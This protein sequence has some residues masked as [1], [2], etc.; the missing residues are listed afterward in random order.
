MSG[1]PLALMAGLVLLAPCARAD[2]PTAG[3]TAFSF[4]STDVVEHLDDVTGAVRVHYSVDGPSVTVLDDAD[5]DG[6]PDFPQ[7]VAS[8]GA[9][10]LDHYSLDMGLRPPVS[11]AELGFGRLGGSDAFDFYL[12]DFGGSSDGQFGVDGCTEVPQRCSGFMVMENDFAGYGYANLEQA[13][14]VLTSHELF[15]AV[16]AAYDGELPVWVSEGTAAW[17]ERTYDPGSRDFF[18]FVDAYFDDTGRSIDRPPTGPVPA[19][20]YATA[21]WWDFLT[22]RHDDDLIGEYLTAMERTTPAPQDALLTLSAVLEARGDALEEAWST[23]ARWNLATGR[24]AGLAESY[25]YAGDVGV[26]RATAQG[27]FIDEEHRFYPLAASYFHVDHTGGPLWFGLDEGAPHLWFAVFRVADGAVD[28]PV[29][30]PVAVWEGTDA[31]AFALA[32]GADLPAGG[33]WMVGSYSAIADSSVR[34]RVCLGDE[35]AASAC[36]PPPDTGEDTGTD[37]PGCGCASGGT[38][39][40]SALLG[41]IA[42]LGLRR[43]R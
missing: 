18:Q 42:L 39:S 4:E 10:V 11:E 38:R 8:V 5:S 12:V 14:D 28:G 3:T 33:Y 16:Q 27:P 15:H 1:S 25:P 31:G 7:L 40:G 34:V 36:V 26:V 13:V 9:D 20:A 43:R 23:F 30:A 22:I 24:R 32:D 17:A 19:F 21:L 37:A 41:L 35:T 2:R 29:Q 6:L